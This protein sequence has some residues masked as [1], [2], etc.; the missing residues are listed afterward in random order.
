M[1]DNVRALGDTAPVLG[2][3]VYIDPAAVVIGDVVLG[4]QVSIWPMATVRGDVNYIRIGARTNVQDGC[5]LHVA[6]KGEFGPGAPLI[7]GDDVTLGHKAVLHACT[8]GDRCLVGI[9]AVVMDHVV[10]EDEVLI[11]ACSL[12]TP[13]KVLRSGWL[14]AGSPARAV[15]ELNDRER[16]M[17]LYSAHHYVRVKDR[18]LAE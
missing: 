2:E 5:V 4:D 3:G 8:V 6:H 9:N 18:Y 14:Y 11:A 7:I 12:V 1:S 10:V 15:R 13:K 17:L 16:E